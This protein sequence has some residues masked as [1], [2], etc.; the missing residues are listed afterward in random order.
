MKYRFK[1]HKIA[2]FWLILWWSIS[3]GNSICQVIKNAFILCQCNQNFCEL[4]YINV[5][6]TIQ[7]QKDRE[8]K[9]EI[10]IQSQIQKV[11]YIRKKF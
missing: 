6:S 2:Y 8:K 11:N 5:G 1:N 10:A 3:N 9:N 4:I 7:K